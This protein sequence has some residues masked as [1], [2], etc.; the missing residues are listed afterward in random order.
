MG[1]AAEVALRYFQALSDGDVD[2]AVELVADGGDFRTPAGRM[3]GKGA[4]RGWLGVFD[5]AFPDSHFDV[6][7]VLEDEQLVAVEGVYRGTHDGPLVTPDGQSLPA[8]GR[9]VRAPFTTVFEVAD[10]RIRS[11]RP[12]WD[13]AGFMAQLTA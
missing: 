13:V 6:E 3:D 2:G 9:K 11:H 1:E 8:T 12:Y 10:G 5:A 4:I 7:H